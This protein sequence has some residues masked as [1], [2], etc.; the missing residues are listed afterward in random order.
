MG[1]RSSTAHYIQPERFQRS[2]ARKTCT[3]S[4][5][6]RVAAPLEDEEQVSGPLGPIFTSEGFSEWRIL[7]DDSN[8]PLNPAIS[9]FFGIQPVTEAIVASWVVVAEGHLVN[10]IFR[11]FQVP[12]LL[13]WDSH[14]SGRPNL[15]RLFKGAKAK[16]G[17]ERP[18]T[19]Q[20][21]AAEVVFAENCFETVDKVRN[22]IY[23]M[24]SCMFLL[25]RNR[26]SMTFPGAARSNASG[27]FP[28]TSLWKYIGS[29]AI[30]KWR[31][32]GNMASV[33]R[34]DAPVVSVLDPVHWT[35]LH[36]AKTRSNLIPR[37]P[38][39]E[40]AVGY[41][42]MLEIREMPEIYVVHSLNPPQLEFPQ[43]CLGNFDKCRSGES[44]LK[45]PKDGHLA[46]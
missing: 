14:P 9:Y 33:P 4:F 11:L 24:L 35:L 20:H 44:E 6:T 34:S 22:L 43:G 30:D 40:K 45:W 23:R 26:N 46:M 10:I 28:N 1:D 31:S 7:R 17:E 16:V 8:T 15:G 42:E 21:H 13:T 36:D 3:R 38:S 32:E 27:M 29:R 39:L 2:K 25:L 19:N 12:F 37:L 5:S 41:R 18:L